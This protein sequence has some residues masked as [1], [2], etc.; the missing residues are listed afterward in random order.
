MSDHNSSVKYC[1]APIETINISTSHQT[2]SQSILQCSSNQM[3]SKLLKF[4]IQTTLKPP[5]P[6]IPS[7]LSKTH[8]PSLPIQ[9]HQHAHFSSF[10]QKP[11]HNPIIPSLSLNQRPSY[12]PPTTK[13]E[14]ILQAKTCLST[15]LEKPLNNPRLAGKLKKLKQPRYRVEIPVLDISP[16]SLVQLALQLFT[17]LPIQKKGTLVKILILWPNPTLKKLADSAFNTES[18]CN[19]VENSALSSINEAVGMD[20]SGI[21]SSADVGIFM[22]PASNQLEAMK[23]VCDGFY[24]KPLVVF[25]P[26]WAYEEESGFGVLSGFVGSFEVVYSFMGLE[27][28]GVLSKRQGMVFKCGGEGWVVLVEEKGDFKVV[29]RFKKRPSVSEVE[30]VLYNLMAVN[31]P[32]TKSVKFIRDLVSNI[33]VKREK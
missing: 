32:V 31:S 8:F 24:P 28:R 5:N 21:L 11:L 13:Q 33:G 10:P 12:T 23:T 30:N 20:I 22:A 9:Q 26:G 7:P 29:S 2:H 1:A 17:N 27:V 16:E 3:A 6:P 14:A 15:S 4:P 19:S 18:S 25:N